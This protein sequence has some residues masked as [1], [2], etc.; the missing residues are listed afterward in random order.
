MARNQRIY[1]HGSGGDGDG[2]GKSYGDC[3]G[4]GGSKSDC[5]GGGGSGGG[6]QWERHGAV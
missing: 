3:N 1:S 4:S 6:Q 2:G 5:N